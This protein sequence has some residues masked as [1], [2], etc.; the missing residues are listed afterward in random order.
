MR[1]LMLTLGAL[2]LAVPTVIVPT[3]AAQAQSRYHGKTVKKVCRRSKGTTGLVTGG[4]GGAVAGAA[5]GGGVLGAV[6]GGIG[7]AVAGKAIDKSITA[8]K[9]CRYVEVRR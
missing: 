5:L 3:S 1:R 9:R 4:V 7:G 2:S 8:K 6:A